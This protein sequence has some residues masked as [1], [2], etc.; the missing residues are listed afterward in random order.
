MPQIRDRLAPGKSVDGLA[1]ESALWCRY[2]HGVSE[3]GR[4]IEPND[5]DWDRLQQRARAAKD[6]P[7]S[8]LGM[9][10]VYG[11]RAA[12]PSSARPSRRR[13]APSGRLVR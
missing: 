5:P 8:W 6:D 1:L 10:D 11:G 4:A 3:S 2:C 7:A 12:P 9:E 13:C